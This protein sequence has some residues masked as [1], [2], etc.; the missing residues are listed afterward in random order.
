ML[1]EDD[2]TNTTEKVIYKVR[3]LL[4]QRDRN[5]RLNRVEDGEIIIVDNGAMAK[6]IFN[7]HKTRYS[8]G[9]A[10]TAGYSGLCE[11]FIPHQFE[12]GTLAY[13]PDDNEYIDRYEF[14]Y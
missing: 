4:N 1:K 10:S 2:M 13:W 12:N 3:F 6:E 14:G 9:Y 8:V 11:V 7:D 5:H